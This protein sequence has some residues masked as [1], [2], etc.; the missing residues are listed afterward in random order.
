MEA[1]TDNCVLPAFEKWVIYGFN[2]LIQNCIVIKNIIIQNPKPKVIHAPLTPQKTIPKLYNFVS[3]ASPSTSCMNFI[4]IES[5]DSEESQI[6][7][8]LFR[9]NT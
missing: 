5:L 9:R 3:E 7:V 6:E 2:S 1:N 8:S 4:L